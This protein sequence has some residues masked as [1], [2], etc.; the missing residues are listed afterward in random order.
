M[1]LFENLS[2]LRKKITF[3]HGK[4]ETNCIFYDCD[5]PSIKSHTLSE[6]RVLKLLEGKN[7]KGQTVVYHIDDVPEVD[8]KID[9]SLSTYH[10]T[11]RKLFEKGKSETSI[12]YGF[13]ASCDS[14]IF[15][16]IDN[17]PYHDS[18]EINFLH[19]FRN[20]A[21]YLTFHRN[22]YKSLY[23]EIC[24]KL[25]QIPPLDAVFS[26]P[27]KLLHSYMDVIPDEYFVSFDEA[28][29]LGEILVDQNTLPLKNQR[30]QIDG[31]QQSL[32]RNILNEKNFPMPAY[33]FKKEIYKVFQ[34]G[35]DVSQE[36]KNIDIENFI[37]I[38][39]SKLDIF[40]S[41]I[42]NI[43]I[44]MRERDFGCFHYFH[45]SVKGI[46]PIAGAFT[47]L[48]N[49]G[50]ECCL[51]FF[52]ENE[53]QQTHFLFAFSKDNIDSKVNVSR[54][55]IFSETELMNYVTKLILSRGSN[56]YISPQFWNKLPENVRTQIL[57]DKSDLL[58]S[59]FNFFDSK[60][61]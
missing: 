7:D 33:E 61:L 44:K 50:V 34:I 32:F 45:N 11:H 21:Y 52:P 37:K 46:F 3:L 35:N 55:N 56:V 24:E 6:S 1:G 12:F 18:P 20:K 48:M 2:D 40:N 19:T 38:I 14:E 49:Y 17:F 25:E 47:F 26:E 41:D 5:N 23:F 22:I 58:N 51:T 59:D 16:L 29:E 31:F 54:L 13:C 10:K 30:E 42:K 36:W 53:T 57:S 15:R 4:N 43:G 60:F 27:M 9:K 8:F 28:R 39:K